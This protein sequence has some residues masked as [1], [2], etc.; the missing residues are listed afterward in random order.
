MHR[1]WDVIPC[2]LYHYLGKYRVN[3][4]IIAGLLPQCH[5]LVQGSSRDTGRFV[6]KNPVYC[7][8]LLNDRQNRWCMLVLP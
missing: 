2:M 4:V 8:C 1:I 6:V 5:G 3:N 7:K